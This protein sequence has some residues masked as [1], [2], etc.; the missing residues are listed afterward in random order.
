MGFPGAQNQVN[1][2][3]DSKS[4]NERQGNDIA[5]IEGEAKEVHCAN[6]QDASEQDRN[7]NQQR[8]ADVAEEVEQQK[9]DDDESGYACLFERT[10][11]N[12]ANTGI[13]PP[14]ASS[15]HLSAFHILELAQHLSEQYVRYP[16]PESVRSSIRC[17]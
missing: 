9:R 14:I 11:N 13:T 2:T 15:S 10:D 4:K 16:P 7:K 6:E 17:F 8:F 12:R 3:V 5:E 1:R